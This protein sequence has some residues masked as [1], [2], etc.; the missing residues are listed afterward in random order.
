VRMLPRTLQHGEQAGLVDHLTEL[1]A[2][3]FVSGAAV[4][5]GFGLA[6][7]VHGELLR[8]L[9]RPL[10]PDRRHLVTFGVTEPF[11]TSIKVSFLA[12]L[13]LALP[14]LLWQLWSFLTPALDRGA[15]RAVAALVASAS[16]LLVVGMAFGYTVALPAAVQ[17]LT[18]YDASVYD[19]QIRASDYLSFA[20]TVLL[21]VGLVFELPVFILGLVRLRVLTAARL[22][23]SR[24]MGYFLVACLAVALPGVDPVT[25]MVEMVPLG[26]LFEA[27][28]W[29]SVLFERRWVA[30]APLW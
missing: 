3:L 24:R 27:S 6:Y 9:E 18:S 19:I 23:R 10:P 30:P 17:F 2:R 14:V 13:A 16:G 21:A 7:A 22:R 4:L 25:T 29:L 28:I 1:R 12:G 8:W 5:A 26:L 20:T 11:T 15:R